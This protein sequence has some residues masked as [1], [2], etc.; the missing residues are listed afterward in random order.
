MANMVDGVPVVPVSL[1][2]LYRVDG[3]SIQFEFICSHSEGGGGGIISEIFTERTSH[4]RLN[5]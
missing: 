1:T 2:E 4:V 5:V 3:I